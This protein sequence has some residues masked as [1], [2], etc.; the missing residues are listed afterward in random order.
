MKRTIY[1]IFLTLFLNIYAQQQFNYKAVYELTYKT[2]S[3]GVYHNSEV[4]LL[5]KN[6]DNS[7]FRDYKRFKNDSIQST[8]IR[9]VGAFINEIVT[10][11]NQTKKINIHRN[12][13]NTDVFY[14]ESIPMAWTLKNEES[15]INGIK[16]RKATLQTYGRNW[17]ACYSEDYP[18]QFGP[19]FFAG[20]PGLILSVEDDQKFYQ[21]KLMSFKK[22]DNT[23]RELA[24]AKELYKVK[25]YQMVY[26]QDFTGKFFNNFRMVNPT[27]QEQFRKKYL[28]AM[29]RKNTFPIDKSMRYLFNK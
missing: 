6:N 29:K 27:E 14:T 10:T 15:S 21:F 26:E 17:N 13:E 1:L 5:M 22:E 16:C 11:N 20:L 9:G 3:V 23:I 24:K 8:E 19:Y 28:E 25:F 7:Y 18:F 12:F 4:V 2:D